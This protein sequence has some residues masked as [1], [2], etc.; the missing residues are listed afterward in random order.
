[1][2]Y[3]EHDIKALMDMMKKRGKKFTIPQVLIS[4]PILFRLLF[5]FKVKT[6]MLHLLNGIKFMHEEYVVHRDL[7]TSNLLLSNKGILKVILLLLLF[8]VTA[9][10]II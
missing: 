4:M 2:D 5:L 6:L 8:T 1:M 3:V 9:L 10:K 7:K